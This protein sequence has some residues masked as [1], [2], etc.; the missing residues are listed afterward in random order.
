MVKGEGEGLAELE[1]RVNSEK[2][3]MTSHDLL[4]RSGVEKSKKESRDS[5]AGD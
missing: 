5:S 2:G 1:L 3:D 4:G